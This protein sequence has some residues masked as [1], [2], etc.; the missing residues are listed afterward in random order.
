M[1]I[2]LL[3]RTVHPAV[4]SKPRIMKIMNIVTVWRS[5]FQQHE[6]YN[7]DLS[8]QR[9]PSGPALPILS[10]AAQAQDNDAK[11]RTAKEIVCRKTQ[12]NQYNAFN[13]HNAASALSPQPCIF[14][15]TRVPIGNRSLHPLANPGNRSI[16]QPLLVS[17]IAQRLP[18]IQTRCSKS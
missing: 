1:S 14:F 6:I 7:S 3:A 18:S 13:Q 17:N 15:N 12:R 5:S 16:S 11:E 8:V 2:P 9:K 10:K 4:S